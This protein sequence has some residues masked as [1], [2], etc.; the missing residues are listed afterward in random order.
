MNDLVERASRLPDPLERDWLTEQSLAFRNVALW[1][2]G[3]D[4]SY[5]EVVAGSLRVDPRPPSPARLRAARAARDAALEEAGYTSFRP[6]RADHL[7]PTQE[8]EGRAHELV[9]ELRRRTEQ[10]LP[11]LRLPQDVIGIRIV[12]GTAFSAY[13]D[14]P[15][16]AV[17]INAD[18]PLTDGELKHLVAH[19][20][21]PGHD[22]HMGHRDAMVRSGEML[23]DGA[24]VVTN[25][26][27]SVLFEGIAE[28]GL[29]LLEW[30]EDLHDRIAWLHERLQWLASIEAAHALNVGRST[31]AE[32][33]RFLR[34]VCDGEEAWIDA[35]L[36]FVTHPLRAPFVYAYW[37]G[38]AI[39]G[40][41]LRKVPALRFVAAARHLYDQMHSP[42]TLV[43]HW[44]EE[45]DLDAT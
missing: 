11:H 23:A 12:T 27:S 43:A 35:K 9:A 45:G 32:V 40:A 18:V 15:G 17:W 13:C 36:R 21:Y 14:Y 25:T 5:E 24:L 2:R 38:G 41:W 6:Y 30:R 37:W 10:R 7:V 4:M 28:R 22:A 16:R 34:D 20:A 42:T 8:L 3:D 1:L 31:Q 39:V 44:H 33:A 29:D 26:A 19:E